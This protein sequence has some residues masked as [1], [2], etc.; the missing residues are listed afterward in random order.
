MAINRNHQ[1]FQ[2]VDQTLSLF[3]IKRDILQEKTKKKVLLQIQ[4][5][6]RKKIKKMS[7]KR[8]PVVYVIYYSTYGH[9]EKLAR[10]VTKGLESSGVTA[11]LY[12][13]AETLPKEVLEKMHAPPKP[14]DVPVISVDQLPEADGILNH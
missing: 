2:S 11:K 6:D 8:Q 12:Q 3:D 14:E 7:E 4:R 9:I 1:N 13:V 10:H 5:F